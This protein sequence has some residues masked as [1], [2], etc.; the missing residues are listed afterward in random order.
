MSLATILNALLL[1]FLAAFAQ[2][3][4]APAAIILDAV[5]GHGKGSQPDAKP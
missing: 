1:P 2:A 5:E 3:Q 4:T